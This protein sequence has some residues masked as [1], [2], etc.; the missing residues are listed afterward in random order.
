MM[1]A[2]PGSTPNYRACGRVAYIRRGLSEQT[3]N[4]AVKEST[5]NRVPDSDG[6][7]EIVFVFDVPFT[8]YW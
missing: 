8:W 7:L 3:P 1:Q 6:I 5:L 4:A 2:K